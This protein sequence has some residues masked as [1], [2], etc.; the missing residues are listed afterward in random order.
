[1]PAQ[2]QTIGSRFTTLILHTSAYIN[3]RKN[4]L[5]TVH[6]LKAFWI[7]LKL[8]AAEVF[9]AVIS[10]PVYLAASSTST[11]DAT[12]Q[13]KLRRVVT[14]SLLI[15]LVVIWLIKLI[16]I[17]AL[18]FQQSN[19]SIKQTESTSQ[20]QPAT[21]QHVLSSAPDKNLPAPTLTSV[22]ERN[23]IF[24]AS[25][26]AIANSW[27]VITVMNDPATANDHPK[28]YMGQADAR[29]EFAVSQEAG[30]FDLPG[31]NYLASAQTYNT[32]S[33]ITSPASPWVK[34]STRPTFQEQFLAQFDRWLNILAML[35]IL[36]ALG[37]TV[38]TI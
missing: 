38:L 7:V 15:G 34:F 25:G 13:Y 22:G 26:L 9:L 12:A 20:W 3:N 8:I 27:L 33:L 10:L 18:S 5:L 17:A 14:M 32:Q 30:A 35:L 2:T 4:E 28:M 6:A 16:V 21:I 19:L 31:G 36:L 11:S 24:T 29:G 23:G 37:V 1:M